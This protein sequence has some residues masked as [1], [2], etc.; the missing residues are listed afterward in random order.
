MGLERI[1]K[2]EF[3]CLGQSWCNHSCRILRSAY[4]QTLSSFTN[5]G[6]ILPSSR[7]RVKKRS[8]DILCI[9]LIPEARLV[10]CLF[11]I[12]THPI[13]TASWRPFVL[14]HRP[15]YATRNEYQAKSQN[16]MLHDCAKND[17]PNRH[18]ARCCCSL[19]L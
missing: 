15:R 6:R 7:K 17:Y 18:P 10:S 14:Y 9:L 8:C 19:L 3:A 12:T 5:V 1:H 16:Q 4:M 2:I 13:F 11:T